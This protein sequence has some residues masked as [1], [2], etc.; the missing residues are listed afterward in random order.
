MGKTKDLVQ[1]AFGL[2]MLKTIALEPNHGWAIAKRLQ[3]VSRDVVQV[4][5]G[6]LY[7]ASHRLEQKAGIR[8]KWAETD[9]VRR[10]KF[11]SLTAAAPV[12]LRN[13]AAHWGRL[14]AAANLV[15]QTS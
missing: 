3:Q 7:L 12:Q 2:L 11:N 14:S 1:R 9:T 4:Q 15:V 13:E 5:Q 10:A 8:A 6:S